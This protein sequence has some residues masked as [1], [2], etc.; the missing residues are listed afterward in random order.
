MHNLGGQLLRSATLIMLAS[1]G[2]WLIYELYNE[3][4]SGWDVIEFWGAAPKAILDHE[5]LS[6]SQ[7]RH[8]SRHSLIGVLINAA[9]FKVATL[10]NYGIPS[11]WLLTL[12]Y[13][14]TLIN[15]FLLNWVWHRSWIKSLIPVLLT[16]SLPLFE[17]HSILLGYMDFTIAL[18][19][20]NALCFSCWATA[21][22]RWRRGFFFCA[23]ILAISPVLLKNIGIVY[24]GSMLVAF[25]VS[26]L[27]KSCTAKVR[28]WLAA[29]FFAFILATPLAL[30]G[31]QD[32]FLEAE[33]SIFRLFSLCSDS[34]CETVALG[35][36][37]LKLGGVGAIELL[38]ALA[39][40]HFENLSFSVAF[41]L[42]CISALQGVVSSSSGMIQNNLVLEI[43][44]G[45]CV[46]GFSLLATTYNFFHY[47][48]GV[49]VGLS[50]FLLPSYIIVPLVV[51][52]IIF[53]S[54]RIAA[55]RCADG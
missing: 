2:L 42:V 7:L 43:Y 53:I 1:Y 33:A 5:G 12:G 18:A 40:A 31:L 22:P 34:A 21:L 29:S 36:Y 47:Y 11:F 17:N 35:G 28:H 44:F 49:D 14:A 30:A 3:V 23:L 8:A 32:V 20:L 55:S 54:D 26:F 52:K 15:I 50:R 13:V 4:N 37:K 25:T 41:I 24:S 16:V 48:V 10:T 51:T 6:D 27:F 45:L 19:V 39:V 9:S 38:R 46:F